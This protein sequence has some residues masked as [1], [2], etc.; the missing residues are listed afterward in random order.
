L[1]CPA[2][3]LP[4]YNDNLTV[5]YQYN[6]KGELY[7]DY[8]NSG[9]FLFVE[10]GNNLGNNLETVEL[11]IETYLGM[12]TSFELIVSSHVNWLSN[13]GGHTGLWETIPPVNAIAFYILKAGNAY[14][15]YQAEP[16]EGTGSWSTYDLSQFGEGGLGGVQ[17]SHYTGYYP[18]TPVPE[19]AMMLLVGTGLVGFGVFSRRKFRK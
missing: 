12:P 1:S 10:P 7:G 3:A 11:Q 16:P 4:I 6:D 19:P 14:A 5:P 2:W 18:D 15:V 8:V 17:I 9:D 13:D